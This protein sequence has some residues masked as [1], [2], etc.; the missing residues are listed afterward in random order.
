MTK[1]KVGLDAKWLPERRT[2]SWTRRSTRTSRRSSPT[3]SQIAV[4]ERFALFYPEKRP[5]FLEHVDLLQ[6]PIQAVYT[7]TIT[8]PLWGARL[9]GQVGR[10]QLHG[11][12]RRTTA[13]GGTVIIPGPVF[14]DTAPQDFESYGR[15]SRGSARISGASFAGVLGDRRA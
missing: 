13:G 12:R 15:A 14:S 9:T 3:S 7:R 8:S 2:R 4:N 5:F 11:A 1:G 6:T 10:H